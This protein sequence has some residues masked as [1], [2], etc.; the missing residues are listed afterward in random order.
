MF[1][2]YPEAH[3]FQT[4]RQADI[5]SV[6]PKQP[7]SQTLEMKLNKKTFSAP[8]PMNEEHPIGRYTQ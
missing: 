3:K 1:V 7:Q 2:H 4:L 6:L 8:P 5:Y